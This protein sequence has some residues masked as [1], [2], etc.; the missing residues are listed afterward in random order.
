MVT[1]RRGGFLVVY[2]CGVT[3]NEPTLFS[4]ADREHYRSQ[5]EDLLTR[6]LRVV[7]YMT[8]DS[9]PGTDA[10]LEASLTLIRNISIELRILGSEDGVPF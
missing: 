4:E 10:E 5:L 2:G 7:R 3:I 8:T 9:R 6:A 1:H